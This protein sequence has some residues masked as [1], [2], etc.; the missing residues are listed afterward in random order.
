MPEPSGRSFVAMA[1]TRL[2]TRRKRFLRP[3][4]ADGGELVCR[5]RCSPATHAIGPTPSGWP[6]CAPRPASPFTARIEFQLEWPGSYLF[7][8]LGPQALGGQHVP[9]CAGLGRCRAALRDRR[10]KP[11][12]PGRIPRAPTSCAPSYASSEPGSCKT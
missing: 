9:H 11:L 6:G 5:G 10:S 8:R 4:R 7:H 3:A 12:W 1:Y 2:L